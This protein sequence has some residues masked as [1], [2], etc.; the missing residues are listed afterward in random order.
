MSSTRLPVLWLCGPWGVGK[1][2]TAWE[3]FRQFDEAGTPIG[4][5]E[6]DAISICF[7]APDD[8]PSNDRLRTANLGAIGSTYQALGARGLIL[9]GPAESREQLDGLV[10]R[11]PGAELTVCRLRAD[12]QQLRSRFTSRGLWP[13]KVDEVVRDAE[14]MDRDHFADFCVDTTGRSIAEAARLVRKQTGWTP[15]AEASDVGSTPAPTAEPARAGPPVPVLWLC[16]PHG[17]GKT[18]IGYQVALRAWRSGVRAAF[19]DLDQV[20]HFGPRTADDPSNQHVKAGGLGAVWRGYVDGGVRRVIVAGEVDD[21]DVVRRYLDMVPGAELTLCRL[22]AGHEQLVERIQ[23]SA[24]HGMAGQPNPLRGRT[25]HELRRLADEASEAGDRLARNGF[26]D[27]SVDTSGKTV[28]EVADLVN[29]RW[30]R[31]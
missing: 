7:P 13:D 11:I 30:A 14:A 10:D 5:V 12:E 2:S 29:D 24:L 27:H 6:L 31:A 17:V 8:D 15:L 28:A 19:L 3:L 23:Q 9:T 16:G 4:F 18:V 1:T 21:A 26:G 25:D 20:G 22:D